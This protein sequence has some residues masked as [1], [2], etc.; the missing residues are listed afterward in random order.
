MS[1]TGLSEPTEPTLFVSALT[2]VLD[3]ADISNRELTAVDFGPFS[4]V[5]RIGPTAFSR[6]ALESICLPSSMTILQLGV[7]QSVLI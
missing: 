3:H 5:D 1:F 2:A 7:L 6:T 4:R